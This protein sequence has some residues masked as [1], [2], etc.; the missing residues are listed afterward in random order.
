MANGIESVSLDFA[1]CPA[2]SLGAVVE[3]VGGLGVAS[4]EPLILGCCSES[5]PAA[6][7]G[8]VIAIKGGAADFAG[9]R[10]GRTTP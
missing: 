1:A 3:G 10:D 2:I 7:L 6:L 9:T 4:G 8:S 5:P